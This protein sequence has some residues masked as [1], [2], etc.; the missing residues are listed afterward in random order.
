MPDRFFR[1]SFF[2]ASFSNA[3]WVSW[4]FLCWVVCLAIYPANAL[5]RRAPSPPDDTRIPA[6]RPIRTNIQCPTELKGLMPFML[7]DLP[8][9]ANRVSQRDDRPERIA[10]EPRYVLITG[11]PEYEPLPLAA[12]AYGSATETDAAVKEDAETESNI[13]QVFF[14]TL[15]RQYFSRESFLVQHHHWLFLTRTENGW[16]FVL[17]QST[18]G[19]N[20]A[21]EPPTPPQDSS[22]GV[23]ARAIQLWLRDCNAGSVGA[24]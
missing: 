5:A 8:S 21:E 4:P 24:L 18:L 16:R 22:Q 6:A 3:Q 19:N 13:P 12:R 15:E 17:M 1:A 7:R 20:S 2:R 10:E 14:T 9:Y 11:N 23:I